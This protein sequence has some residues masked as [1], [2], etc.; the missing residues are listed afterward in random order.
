MGP[1]IAAVVGFIKII[2]TVGDLFYEAHDKAGWAK[3]REDCEA[4]FA[5]LSVKDRR[6]TGGLSPT[7]S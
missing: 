4:G 3:E 6:I 1:P 2:R 5:N 7:F